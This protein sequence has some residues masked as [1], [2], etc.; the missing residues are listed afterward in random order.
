MLTIIRM[1]DYLCLFLFLSIIIIIFIIYLCIFV[2][3]V[4]EFTDLFYW[5]IY[6]DYLE[7]VVFVIRWDV[8]FILDVLTVYLDFFIF[9]II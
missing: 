2:I 7:V 9:R 5:F 1:Y 4:L 3:V 8:S 6:L